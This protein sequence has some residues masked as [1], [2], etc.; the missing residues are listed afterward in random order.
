MTPHIS[1][2]KEDIA[3]TVLMPG[4]PLRAKMI[5]EAYLQDAKLVN[6]VRGMLAYTG[7]YQG[8]RVTVMASGMGIPSIGIY[9][10]ELFKFYDVDRII[11]IGSCGSYDPALHLYDV[12]LVCKSYSNSTY[13][14]NQN[15]CPFN[16]LLSSASLNEKIEKKAK[17]QGINLHKGTV[18]CS[19]VFYD[20]VNDS[21]TLYEEKHCM[22][23]EMESFALFHNA[24]RFNKQA[25][26]LLT[27][28]DDLTR[29]EKT[30]P[31]ERQ[32]AFHEMITLALSIINE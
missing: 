13:A 1:A 5:A 12:L 20:E 14:K 25:T 21:K 24:N 15:G 17:E 28:S 10:Y 26:C 9:S 7:T 16:T 22:A 31:E 27:V 32:N 3:K 11:R 29:G 19:D 8:E 18:Y 30:T 6:E 4:D 2:K 23:T